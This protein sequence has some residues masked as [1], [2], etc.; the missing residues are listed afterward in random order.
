MS[1][2]NYGGIG[3]QKR[4]LGLGR[5][6]VPTDSGQIAR[7]SGAGETGESRRKEVTAGHRSYLPTTVDNRKPLIGCVDEAH[8]KSIIL[9][10]TKN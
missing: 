7:Y 10:T 2:K 3:W 5:V 1:G 9:A 4:Y 8:N 6:R